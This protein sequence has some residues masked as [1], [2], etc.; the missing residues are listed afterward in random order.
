MSRTLQAAGDV[1]VVEHGGSYVLGVE[2]R[3]VECKLLHMQLTADTSPGQ[4]R[5]HVG[6]APLTA[7]RAQIMS[8]TTSTARH[9]PSP[10]SLGKGDV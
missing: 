3:A 8:H 6:S 7:A 10:R 4:A 2:M 5:D 1:A 9:R